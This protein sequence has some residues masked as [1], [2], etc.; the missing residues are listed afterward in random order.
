[1]AK[2]NIPC[3]HCVIYKCFACVVNSN[4]LKNNNYFV[5]I[6][7]THEFFVSVNSRPAEIR[8]FINSVPK[9][10]KSNVNYILTHS[11][12]FQMDNPPQQKY[13]LRFSHREERCVCIYHF[14][15]CHIIYVFKCLILIII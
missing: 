1:M 12:V 9:A 11:K 2:V 5:P 4:P 14:I 6:Y 8:A 13:L 7:K 15:I 3:I 10:S